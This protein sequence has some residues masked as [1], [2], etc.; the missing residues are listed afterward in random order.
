MKSFADRGETIVKILTE[1]PFF[2]EGA[3]LGWLF[4][5]ILVKI[6]FVNNVV[7]PVRDRE[8]ISR[9]SLAVRRLAI[10][11]AIQTLKESYGQTSG[12]RAP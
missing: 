3:K 1:F 6:D 2:S 10:M 12:F 9:G 7:T 11:Q 4:T 5:L 8:E